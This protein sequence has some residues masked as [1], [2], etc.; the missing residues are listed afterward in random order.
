LDDDEDDADFIDDD[1][2]MEYIDNPSIETANNSNNAAATAAD[3]ADSYNVV[4][5][6]LD[7]DV[8]EDNED[9]AFEK[10]ASIGF[11]WAAEYFEN[12]GKSLDLTVDMLSFH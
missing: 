10:W 8:V 12:S 5:E 7:A 1:E 4:R 11:E 3:G 2:I 6:T 9:A